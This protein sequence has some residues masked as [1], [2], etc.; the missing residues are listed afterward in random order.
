M[1]PAL[2]PSPRRLQTWPTS[3]H[4]GRWSS[5]NP[6]EASDL[7]SVQMPAGVGACVIVANTDLLQDIPYV[8]QLQAPTQDSSFDLMPS[9]LT[10]HL[11]NMPHSI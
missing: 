11:D 8:L 7:Y 5:P 3:A 1:G 9:T 2:S 10:L 6:E 4:M